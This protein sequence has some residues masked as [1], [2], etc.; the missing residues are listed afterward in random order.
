[1]RLLSDKPLKKKAHIKYIIL[2]NDNMEAKD[3]TINCPIHMADF[4]RKPIL[5]DGNILPDIGCL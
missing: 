5:E 3:K 1:M 2:S 4:I